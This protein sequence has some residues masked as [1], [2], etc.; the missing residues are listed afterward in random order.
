MKLINVTNSHAA[1]IKEQLAT[2]AANLLK[3]YTLG[4][5]TVIHADYHGYAQLTITNDFRDINDREA[6]FI[7]QR[8]KQ[9]LSKDRYDFAKVAYKE[10]P[11]LIAITI[12]KK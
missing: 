9:K 10:A 11:G 2:T 6:D 5:T 8:F 3:I 12:P 7:T 1:F 4:K